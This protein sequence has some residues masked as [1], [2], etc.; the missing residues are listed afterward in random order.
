MCDNVRKII[1]DQLSVTKK[2]YNI[3]FSNFNVDFLK[4]YSAYEKQFILH[5]LFSFLKVISLSGCTGI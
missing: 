2:K 1:R 3:N 4:H 5:F